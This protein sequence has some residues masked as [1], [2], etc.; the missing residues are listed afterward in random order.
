MYEISARR[1]PFYN[2]LHDIH[3]AFDICSGI[4]PTIPDGIPESYKEMMIKC[5]DSEPSNRPTTRELQIYFYQQ[6][7]NSNNYS[8]SLVH[9]GNHIKQQINSESHT[10]SCIYTYQNLP[11]PRNAT[12][13]DFD[14]S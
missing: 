11:S 3:L 5:W 12:Q 13:G 14:Q 1:T 7:K 9:T 2:R 10:K 8:A 4:R 6:C